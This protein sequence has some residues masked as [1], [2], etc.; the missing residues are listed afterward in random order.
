MTWM[1]QAGGLDNDVGVAV[2][3]SDTRIF[4]G[5]TVQSTSTF[6]GRGL[7]EQTVQYVSAGSQDA[8]VAALGDCTP[9]NVTI[10][11]TLP[12]PTNQVIVV[13]VRLG[14]AQCCRSLLRMRMH[15][16]ALSHWLL[17]CHHGRPRSASTPLALMLTMSLSPLARLSTLPPSRCGCATPQPLLPHTYNHTSCTAPQLTRHHIY[18]GLAQNNTKVSFGV[19]N[20]DQGPLDIE[21]REGAIF[22]PAGNVN[23]AAPLPFR[24]I[25]D[26][27][28]PTLVIS[29]TLWDPTAADILPLTASFSGAAHYARQRCR[30]HH[31]HTLTPSHPHTLTP[32]PPAVC[33]C[34][35]CVVDFELDDVQLSGGIV[36]ELRQEAVC[37]RLLSF[38]ATFKAVGMEDGNFT[39]N[40]TSGMVTD[41]AGNK[42]VQVGDFGITVDRRQPLATFYSN[43]RN[44]TNG[45]IAITAS[46][47]AAVRVLPC[48]A[49]QYSTVLYSS[50]QL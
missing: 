45:S 3:A 36:G 34:T 50:T 4:V 29:T 26:T 20:P 21:L 46:F 6:G 37:E 24:I 5:G 32:L 25:V 39:A 1:S 18:H 9:P 14:L 22:D 43:T 8:F 33:P 48:S 47:D 31:A 27:V 38:T 42:N 41:I 30:P 15:A 35:E 12:S 40:I 2:A 49:P 19:A 7:G 16:T 10:S 11:T 13:T 23:V 44:P 17:W 28:P